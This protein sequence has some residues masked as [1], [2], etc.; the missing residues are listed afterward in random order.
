M[1]VGNLI[2]IKLLMIRLVTKMLSIGR[3][4]FTP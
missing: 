3:P 2:V 4:S 1:P